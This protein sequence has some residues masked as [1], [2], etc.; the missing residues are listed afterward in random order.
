MRFVLIIFLFS[1]FSFS[2]SAVNGNPQLKSSVT[3]KKNLSE[4]E[5]SD[6]EKMFFQNFE[7]EFAEKNELPDNEKVGEDPAEKPEN[8]KKNISRIE[9]KKPTPVTII[10][11]ETIEEKTDPFV[12]QGEP[13]EEENMQQPEK[14]TKNRKHTIKKSNESESLK[15]EETDDSDNEV[16]RSGQ[17]RK[18]KEL[19]KKRKGKNRIENRRIY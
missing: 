14:T 8:I 15:I 11:K 12:Q 17:I 1:F 3:F 19:L 7:T 5:I 10:K 13:F 18:M 4:S 6:W 2:L 9:N 16:D